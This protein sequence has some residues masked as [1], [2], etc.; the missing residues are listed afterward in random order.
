MSIIKPG[1]EAPDFD[2][3]DHND[4]PFNLS[5]HKGEKILLS[6]HPFAWTSVCAKQMESL[7]RNFNRFK[8]LNAT[9]VGISVDPVPSKKAWAKE[10]GLKNIKILSDFWPHG[11]VIKKYGIF[12]KKMGSSK[13]A[14]I[15]IGE[16]GKIL[17]SKKYPIDEVP[18]VEEI[19]D[20][21]KK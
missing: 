5:E 20:F 16:E 15:I 18:D 8:E 7:D 21:L 2:I 9:P 13:R 6:F 17:F 14:N 11:D 3:H 1:K 4:K 19:L 12:S 10:L